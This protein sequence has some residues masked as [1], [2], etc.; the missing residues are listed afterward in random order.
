MSQPN[1]ARQ[2]ILAE[3][4]S[5]G[6]DRLAHAPAHVAAGPGTDVTVEYLRRA[7]V[8]TIVEGEEPASEFPHAA[9]LRYAAPRAVAE[10]AWAAVRHVRQVLHLGS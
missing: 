5:D 8:Q 1:C 10:G 6:Q 2:K 7:G 4:G 3:V 9:Q